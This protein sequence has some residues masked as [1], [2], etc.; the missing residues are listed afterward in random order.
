MA[1]TPRPV[2]RRLVPGLAL[3]AALALGGCVGNSPYE[4]LMQAQPNGS[5]FARALFQDYSYLA[6][7]FGIGEAPSTSAFDSSDAISIASLDSDVA[8][9]ANAYAEKAL[10]AAKGEEPLPEPAPTD[11]EKAEQLRQRLLRA[12]DQGRTKAPA[13]AARAQ[14]D[15]DCWTLNGTVESLAAAAAACRR[16]FNASLPR[17]ESQLH[18]AAAPAA[19]PAAPSADFTAYFELNSAVLTPDAMAVLRQAIDT[20]RAGRQSRITVAGHT[21][22]VGSAPYN[23]TLSKKRAAAIRDALVSMGARP[24]AIQIS[25]L[26]EDDLAVQTPDGVAEAKNRRGVVTLVP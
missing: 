13:A 11:D 4:D 24:A 9:V 21:D 12:L 17:L 20:A 25:G 26:G 1:P 16:S 7:S 10:V 15:Y 18:L 8:D 5:P 6:R 2:L 3:G 14:A 23:L 22:T 19:A